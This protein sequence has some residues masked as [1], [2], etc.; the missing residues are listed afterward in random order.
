VL[1]KMLVNPLCARQ[2]KGAVSRSERHAF[3][4]NRGPWPIERRPR[5]KLQKQLCRHPVER[6]TLHVTLAKGADKDSP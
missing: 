1:T 5:L 2:I 3:V 6:H 4:E